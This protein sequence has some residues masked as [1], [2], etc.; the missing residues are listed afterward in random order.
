MLEQRS[1]L[2]TLPPELR[3]RIYEY[4]FLDHLLAWHLDGSGQKARK[5]PSILQTCHNIRNEAKSLFYSDET[6]TMERCF[7]DPREHRMGDWAQI[8][9]PEKKESILRGARIARMRCDSVPTAK[10][11][12]RGRYADFEVIWLYNGGWTCAHKWQ[13][14]FTALSAVQLSR[15]SG[16]RS[17]SSGG[18][19]GSLK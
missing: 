18:A 10:A 2:L 12:P 3:N 19:D 4:V 14:E 8:S 5:I 1:R 11:M 7:Q 9:N 6:F 16:P 17:E 15:I 13:R